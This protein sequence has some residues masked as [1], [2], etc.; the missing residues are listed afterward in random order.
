MNNNKKSIEIIS[1]PGLYADEIFDEIREYDFRKSPLKQELLNKKIY[2]YSA[3]NEKAIIGY[4]KVD[5]VLK[6]S[7]N[8]IINMTGYEKDSYDGRMIKEYFADSNSDCYALHLYDVTEFE[9]HLPLGFIRRIN[10]NIDM[11]QYTKT[12][13]EDDPLY[14]LITEWD[15]AYSLDG[16]G[17]S[18]SKYEKVKIL[19]KI[20]E[21][22]NEK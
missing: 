16:N 4:V 6:G 11:P 14:K 10:K 21:K 22:N 18:Y 8:E 15:K 1:I 2:V 7:T 13:Y 20:R 9:E 19:N 5:K 3:R 17:V 12:I